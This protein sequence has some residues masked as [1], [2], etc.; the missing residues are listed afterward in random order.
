MQNGVLLMGV[1]SLLLLLYTH[2]SVAALVVMYSINV[3]ITFSLSQ[4]GM[5][6]F[7]VLR[8]KG[9][10]QWKK[11]IIVHVVGFFVCITILGITVYE[12]FLEGGWLTLLITSSVV[13]LCYVIQR[14]YNKTRAAIRALESTLTDIP[15]VSPYNND[16]V[17]PQ[18]LTATLLVGGFG[19]FGLHTLLSIVRNFPNIYKNFIFVSVGEIDSGSFKGKEAIEALKESVKGDL[20]KYVKLTRKHGFPADYRMDIGIDIAETA[21]DLCERVAVEF[22]RLT[23]FAGKLVFQE[24]NI[25]HR[26]LHNETAFA[27]QRRLQWKG[28]TTVVLPIRVKE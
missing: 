1:A 16:P 27:I 3:F 12:K 7:Y 25:F 18:D 26:L 11:H 8:R 10:E 4:L 9:A 21:T 2:G 20:E 24:E 6:R 14:H 13:G 23:V 22:P 5:I 19:G 15:S 17:N 28:I